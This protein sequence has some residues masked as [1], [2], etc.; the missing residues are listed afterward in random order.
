MYGEARVTLR[1]HEARQHHENIYAPRFVCETRRL[2]CDYHIY[3]SPRMYG[4]VR[5]APREY[6]AGEHYV[7]I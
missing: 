1:D 7:S 6:E 3:D 2:V 5:V 4:E